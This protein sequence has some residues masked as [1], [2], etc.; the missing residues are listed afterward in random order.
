MSTEKTTKPER[1]TD[2]D[3]QVFKEIILR[4]ISDANAS[5]EQLRNFLTLKDDHGTNDTSPTFKLMED[6]ADVSSREETAE[7]A[8]RQA[9]FIQHLKNA[10]V[11]IENKTYGICM[12]SGE[13]I[14]RE[15][16]KSVP[17]ATV[18]IDA[19]MEMKRL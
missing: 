13:L 10:L 4:K 6:A 15:R 14:A 3:L 17:H 12:I 7:L 11:R 9:K 8:S 18:N 2:E 5:Y 1:F 19:K 16:L